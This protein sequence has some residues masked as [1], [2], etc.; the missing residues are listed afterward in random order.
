MNIEN[1]NAGA[2]IY[3]NLAERFEGIV[4]AVALAN[5][6]SMLSSSWEHTEDFLEALGA[7]DHEAIIEARQH[8]GLPILY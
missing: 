8:F 1:F 2:T 4:P 5:L 7:D 3:M 6:E